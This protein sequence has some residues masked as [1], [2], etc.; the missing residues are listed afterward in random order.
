MRM[1][2]SC[3]HGKVAIRHD[4]REYIPANSKKEFEMNNEYLVSS[5]GIESDYEK[6]FGEAVEEYNQ[7]QKRADRKIKSYY[8]KIANSK[9]G[10]KVAYEY[11]IQIGSRENNPINGACQDVSKKIYREYFESF[12]QKNP[13]LK[14]INA[15]IH[16]DEET[17]HMHITVVPVA[18]SNRGIKLKNSLSGAMKEMG[19][20]SPADWCIAQQ[21][22]IERIMKEHNI[23]REIVGCHRKHVENGL[24]QE[25]KD[26]YTNQ[27]AIELFEQS[28]ELNEVKQTVELKNEELSKVKEKLQLANKTIG[29]ADE[30]QSMASQ[31][32]HEVKSR[33]KILKTFD[34]VADEEDYKIT[35]N[36][37]FGGKN[38]VVHITIPKE[39]TDDFIDTL[40]GINSL[41]RRYETEIRSAKNLVSELQ[42]RT[43]EVNNLRLD[44][45]EKENDLKKRE[46]ELAKKEKLFSDPEQIENLNDKIR[47][48][49]LELADTKLQVRELSRELSRKDDELKRAA[50]EYDK[51]E[52]LK[53]EEIDDM[54]QTYENALEDHKTTIAEL[55]TGYEVL[56]EQS[57]DKTFKRL[58]ESMKKIAQKYVTKNETWA[59]GKKNFAEL[60][61]SILPKKSKNLER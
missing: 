19:F 5:S 55:C 28:Q 58:C 17:P 14:L 22:T 7:K 36:G 33:K 23:E 53:N 32:K 24:Y 44:I 34:R 48:T 60:F 21:D 13:N 10:E 41:S 16:C 50:F 54:R 25:L 29:K 6:I 47:K 37:V 35:S 30:L 42:E 61:K 43:S 26:N 1:S 27:I 20:E 40:S 12:E 46:Q 51:L 56:C 15:S 3:S 59:S 4:N 49:E 2:V 31:L 57:E 11:V 9:N 8:Q 38:S 45:Y 52:N 18:H 39:K